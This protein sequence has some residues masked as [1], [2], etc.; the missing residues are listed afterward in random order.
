MQCTF[1]VLADGKERYVELV[2]SQVGRQ[3]GNFL[4]S[5]DVP[6]IVI[7]V[8]VAYTL[9]VIWKVLIREQVDCLVWQDMRS[10]RSQIFFATN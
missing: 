4:H 8:P 2:Y 3:V 7:I 1:A 9:C 6:V 5:S 10:R